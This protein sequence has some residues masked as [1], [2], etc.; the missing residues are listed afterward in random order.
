MS[1][2]MDD[3]VIETDEKGY[4]LNPNDWTEKDV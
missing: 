4:L 1:I 2:K 3:N